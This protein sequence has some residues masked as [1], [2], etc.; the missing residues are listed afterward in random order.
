MM[1][2]T[3]CRFAAAAVF[4]ACLF[5]LCNVP[6]AAGGMVLFDFDRGLD[7]KS[8]KTTDAE[9]SLSGGGKLILQTGRRQTWPGVTL[10]APAGRWDLSAYEYLAVEIRN[11]GRTGASIY[12]RVDNPGADGRSNCVT[13]RISLDAGQTGRLIVRLH[14]TPWVLSEPVDIIGMR[15]WPKASGKLD[16]SNVT[17][18][19]FFVTKPASR[20]S[21]EIDN[22]IAAGRA[23]MIDAKKLFPMIDEFGQFIHDDWPGK[24]HSLAELKE[25]HNAELKDL[26]ANPAPADRN[27]YGGWTKGPA[28]EATGFFS[29]RKYNGKWWLVDPEGRLFWS[30]GID[31]VH[32]GND[33]P[34]TDRQHCFRNLPGP[35]SPFARFYGTGS[36]APH[37][38]YRE[39]LPYR[40][41]DFSRAN[42][43]RKYGD[44]WESD[45][46]G[47]THRR[48]KSWGINTIANWSDP[49]IYLMRRIPYTGNLSFRSP[50]I[51]G[52][53]GYWGKFP[54]PFDP[55]FRRGIRRR[56]AAEKGASLGDPWC[57]GY[58]VHNEL[59]WGDEL[60]LAIA[61]LK[62]PPD[63]P[64]KKAFLTQLKG[65]YKTIDKL[66]DAWGTDYASWDALLESRD[67]PD[68][69]KAR[70]DL[71]AFYTKIAETY[72]RTIR[73]EIKAACPKQMYMGC[74][75]AWVNDRA[76]GAAAKYCDIVCYNRYSYSVADH[77]LPGD[78]DKPII[79]GE[80]HFGAL[81]R[82][83]FHTGLK[84]TLD[85][86]D[87][88]QK[89]TDYVLGALANPCIV[90]TH[91]FQYK[92]QPTTGRG[93]GENYQIG[94]IDICDTP[95]PEIVAAARDIG[96]KM[97]DYRM[98]K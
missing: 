67:A 12:C 81:D 71:A 21:F 6:P 82:G 14:P 32:A 52:S 26:A 92:N 85:Q 39:H 61:S 2:K 23:K 97:Y 65:K 49:D 17:Q 90:G 34:I 91:W 41:Y 75:F 36:W 55:A 13:E 16:T 37:G 43:L 62:S 76:A 98:K 7:M 79:I 25:H 93:D 89:Y 29:V 63:Q 80:F 51:Q 84:K 77:R 53:E 1:L 5:T 10:K 66:N 27:K 58:F 96:A 11:L 33:T 19:L 57:I 87:R 74:R 30:H 46:A 69:K 35:D 95:Y 47:I 22:I 78:L 8:V 28:L 40:T 38:Y 56:V 31:C 4:T 20:H 73:D 83:M 9:V 86:N 24:T 48:L 18:L 42:L 94:F 68:R 72:F 15:G 64:A 45:F 60:S 59:G 70:D 3:E 54:D 50:Q 88:A 44:D